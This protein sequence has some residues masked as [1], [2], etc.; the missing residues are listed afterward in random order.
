[1][2][3]QSQCMLLRIFLSHT[4][5]VIYFWIQVWEVVIQV[6]RAMIA[7]GSLMTTNRKKN[8]QWFSSLKRWWNSQQHR[9]KLTLFHFRVNVRLTHTARTPALGTSLSTQCFPVRSANRTGHK[10]TVWLSVLVQTH[11]DTDLLHSDWE[12]V[13]QGQLA[14]ETHCHISSS[15]FQ[16]GISHA[17]QI[18]APDTLQK[19]QCLTPKC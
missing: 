18:P 3:A 11:K 1:M 12:A 6:N 17:Q 9:F 8:A 7:K 2:K 15:E 19:T 4:E 13:W 16:R 5:H 10:L 14:H